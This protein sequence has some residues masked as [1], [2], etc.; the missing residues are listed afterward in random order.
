MLAGSNFLQRQAKSD[1]FLREF[2]HERPHEALAM[3]CPELV[4]LPT[5]R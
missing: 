3:R 2:N 5:A 1:A 4:R